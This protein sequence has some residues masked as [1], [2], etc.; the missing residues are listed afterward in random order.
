MKKR[1]I[2]Q[3]LVQLLFSNGEEEDFEEFNSK[4]FLIRGG[5][6]HR[7]KS[8]KTAHKQRMAGGLMSHCYAD[9]HSLCVF[10]FLIHACKHHY[11]SLD[12]TRLHRATQEGPTGRSYRKVLHWKV[13]LLIL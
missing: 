6:S 13:L 3:L 11:S 8:E 2:Y 5:R 12:Y 1:N 9:F 7:F 10:Q 4:P